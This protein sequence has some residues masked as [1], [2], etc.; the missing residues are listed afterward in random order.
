MTIR[1]T[2]KLRRAAQRYLDLQDRRT[3]PTGDTDTG[4]RWH[5]AQPLP[6]CGAIRTPSRAWPWSLM[7]HCRTLTHVAHESGYPLPT[8]RAALRRLAGEAR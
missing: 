6:C 1:L 4:G 7:L 3:H 8:L 2:S 5:P